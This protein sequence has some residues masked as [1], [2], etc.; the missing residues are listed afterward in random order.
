MNRNSLKHIHTEE[1]AR[2]NLGLI[3]KHI[4]NETFL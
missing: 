2:F 1:K 4:F 3:L